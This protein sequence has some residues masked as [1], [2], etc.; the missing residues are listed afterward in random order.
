M[1]P[2]LTNVGHPIFLAG[3]KYNTDLKIG[4]QIDICQVAGLLLAMRVLRVDRHFRSTKPLPVLPTPEEVA[5]SGMRASPSSPSIAE[6]ASSAAAS[7]VLLVAG[8]CLLSS[9]RG[10]CWYRVPLSRQ[11]H[12][13]TRP[14]GVECLSHMNTFSSTVRNLFTT[15]TSVKVVALT[16]PL[17]SQPVYLLHKIGY[18]TV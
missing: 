10:A 4:A 16:M 8:S 5:I 2:T 11:T 17:H 3:R 7:A 6:P 13:A 14:S 12:T 9:L 18:K 15:P 1:T